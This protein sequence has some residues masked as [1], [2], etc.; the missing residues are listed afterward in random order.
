MI[1]QVCVK[2]SVHGEEVYTPSKQ[3]PPGR[4]LTG[5][6][7][8]GRHPP[9]RYPPRQTPPHADGYCSRWYASYW[10]PFSFNIVGALRDEMNK[11]KQAW[12]ALAGELE[13]EINQMKAHSSSERSNWTILYSNEGEILHWSV[14]DADI[15][16]D[17]HNKK[18]TETSHVDLSCKSGNFD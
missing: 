17:V 3:T 15:K 14:F 18:T 6:H 9:G 16:R 5:R 1:S 2:N 8:Q 7:P 13:G 11:E 12:Q 10:N 4:H